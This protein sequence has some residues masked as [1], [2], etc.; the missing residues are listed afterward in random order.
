MK[1]LPF[2]EYKVK[3][4]KSTQKSNNNTIINRHYNV[5]D[6]LHRKF[7]TGEDWLFA[8]IQEKFVETMRTTELW[9]I[10]FWAWNEKIYQ[11]AEFRQ[12]FY[13]YLENRYSFP[14]R[15]LQIKKWV[16]DHNL[17][18]DKEWEVLKGN[19][20]GG[21]K[22]SL[23]AAI[24]LTLLNMKPFVE[25]TDD[26]LDNTPLIYHNMMSKKRLNDIRVELGYTFKV[27]KTT[28]PK[29]SPWILLFSHPLWGEMFKE[30]YEYLIRSDGSKKYIGSVGGLLKVLMEYLETHSL[31]DC[32]QF[33]WVDFKSFTE[34][35]LETR[36]VTSLSNM[37]GKY[38]KFF[39]WGNNSNEF[40]P[41][42]LNFPEPYWKSLHKKAKDHS[43][44]SNGLAF[45]HENTAEEIVKA[46]KIYKPVDEQEQLCLFF[47]QIIASCPARFSFVLNIQAEGAIQRL[48]NEPNAFG[49]YSR[50]ADK[51]GNKGGQFPIIDPM[52]VEAITALQLRARIS[53]FKPLYNEDNKT[54]YVH[55]F[56]LSKAPWLINKSMLWTFFNKKIK[57]EVAS[58]MNFYEDTFEGGAHG[59]RH[60][61]LT[62]ILKRT[63]S[64]EAAQVAAGHRHSS[65]TQNYI[66]SSHAKKALLFRAIDKYEM[67]EITGK[68]YLRLIEALTTNEP[69][70]EL[71]KDLTKEMTMDEF[72]KKHGRKTEIGVCFDEEGI[73]N[74]YMK[75]WSCPSFMMT[76]NE[77]EGAV[78]LLK[79]LTV[80]FIKFKAE[81]SNFSYENTISQN[82]LTAISL[83][84]ERL[85]DLKVP[86]EEIV[87]MI[88]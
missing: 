19:G 5:I 38:K 67:G 74:H 21:S 88:F 11:N 49:L 59:F 56:Q 26:D 58:I 55:L 69:N 34:F 62:E 81:S 40:F 25:L 61:I 71:I 33:T 35:L 82:K 32:S 8:P 27:L 75:C 9:Y 20:N 68:F 14:G 31:T 70:S 84:K 60:H 17:I 73:C 86:E 51:A 2:E 66:K 1:W 65:M 53:N 42:K 44:T 6:K 83:I 29:K 47:W 63:G 30:Y 77:I 13:D 78:K 24:F 72:I 3:I 23:K 52:G 85:T 54:T 41:K 43:K 80:D 36:K 64:L 87:S 22:G 79:K 28:Y 15:A 50:N 18:S 45:S 10:L 39:L 57:P 76:R 37:I 12:F 7:K 4:P 16:R 46:I 48:P